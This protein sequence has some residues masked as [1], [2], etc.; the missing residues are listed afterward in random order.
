[1]IFGQLE[2]ERHI[3]DTQ[4]FGMRFTFRPLPT[5]EIGLSRSAQ[6]CGEGRPCDASTFFDLL[7]G[8]DNR[9]DDDINPENEPGNQLAGYD[10]RWS[11]TIFGHRLAAYGQL[12]GEDEAGGFPSRYIGQFGVEWTGYVFDRWSTR[13]RYELPVS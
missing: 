11:P 6:W 12:I 7:L 13:R 3:P 9:G 10:F 8:R 1:V 5:L 4:F 2:N